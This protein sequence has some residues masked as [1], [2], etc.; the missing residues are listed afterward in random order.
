MSEQMSDKKLLKLNPKTLEKLSEK[1]EAGMDYWLVKTFDLV[2]TF[3]N[4]S[5]Q[6]LSGQTLVVRGNGVAIPYKACD[7]YYSMEEFQAGEPFPEFSPKSPNLQKLNLTNISTC[8]I[9]TVSLPQNYISTVGAHPL[10]GTLN[11]SHAAKFYR[12]TSSPTDSKFN[13]NTQTLQAG[14]YLTTDSDQKFVNTGFGAV[15]RFALPMPIPASYKHTYTIPAKN[16]LQVG[17]VAPNFGQSGGGVEVM[18]N[19]SISN[20]VFHTTHQIGDCL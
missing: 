8:S 12:F 7:Q 17:T 11:L 14:T 18:T 13:K 4:S 15:G 16:N 2:E 10:L 19:A 6:E 9:L 3:D 20:V 5:L 1:E